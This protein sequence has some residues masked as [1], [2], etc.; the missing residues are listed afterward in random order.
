MCIQYIHGVNS[1][2]LLVMMKY[3]ILENT[4]KSPTT[5]QQVL[6]FNKT[7]QHRFQQQNV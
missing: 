4:K 1:D 7:K 2:A 6:Y 3:A 5:T